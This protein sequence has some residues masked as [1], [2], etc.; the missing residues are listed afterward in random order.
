[1]KIR[2]KKLHKDAVVPEYSK[3]GDACLD[4]VAVSKS[5]DDFGNVV[6]DTG[7]AL[8]IPP[9]FVGLI[10]PRSSISKTMHQMR[11]SVG[12]IDSGYRGAIKLVFLG[13]HGRARCY[14]EGDRIG[15]LMIL[16]YPK[17]EFEETKELDISDRGSGGF[18]S[19]GV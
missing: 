12:V 14:K 16:P 6:F 18:G 5:S 10:F 9:G 19:T 15:Q 1:M 11:N 17:I 8:Q 3:E 2:I 13:D 4:L 7:L